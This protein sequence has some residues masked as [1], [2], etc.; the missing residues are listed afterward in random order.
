[1]TSLLLISVLFLNHL[2][3]L[4]IY[5]KSELIEINKSTGISN[6]IFFDKGDAGNCL[7]I[8]IDGSVDITDIDLD[9]EEKT[10][11]RHR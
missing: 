10:L 6:N 2:N 5:Q 1:M 4:E 7:Y 9:G 8:L 11:I 3:L